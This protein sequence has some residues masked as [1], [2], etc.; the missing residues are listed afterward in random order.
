MIETAESS[1]L[2]MKQV[3]AH[4][5]S[6]YKTNGRDLPWRRTKEPFQILVAEMLLR[7]TTATAVARVFPDFIL[8]FSTPEL[9]A[10]AR[11]ITIAKQVTTLGL[12]NMRSQQLKYAASRIVSDFGGIVPND[13]EEL[14]SLPGVGRYV[15]SAVLNFAFGK[16]IPLVD[17]NVIRLIS[18]VF[19]SKFDGPSDE[20]AWK[21]M[22]SF[23]AGTQQGAFYWGI[24][25]LVSTV[26]IRTSPRCS[27]CP[28]KE[29]CSWN[30]ERL[31]NDEPA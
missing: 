22:S 7:R 30:N 11:T 27:G 16:P 25:D 24:I 2:K 21:F 23:D 19:G 26:R 6:W 28:L 4:I 14:S 1:K 10:R 29:L 5:I 3:R 17:G 15:A 18:Q 31:E 20:R 8:R 13:Y 9:L 12:Q